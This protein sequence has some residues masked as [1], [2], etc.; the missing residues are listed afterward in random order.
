MDTLRLMGRV[1][2]LPVKVEFRQ[3]SVIVC[4]ELDPTAVSCAYIVVDSNTYVIRGFLR[5][6]LS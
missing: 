1:E 6:V 2:D 3:T 5:M 4:Q